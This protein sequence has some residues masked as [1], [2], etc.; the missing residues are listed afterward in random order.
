MLLSQLDNQEGTRKIVADLLYKKGYCL[1]IPDPKLIKLHL[2]QVSPSWIQQFLL[3]KNSLGL[4]VIP[5]FMLI[6][7]KNKCLTI[8]QSKRLLELLQ[9]L[10]SQA[11]LDSIDQIFFDNNCQQLAWV[12][13]I[14][15]ELLKF[16]LEDFVSSDNNRHRILTMAASIVCFFDKAS[17]FTII[18]FCLN[19]EDI[20]FHSLYKLMYVVTYGCLHPRQVIYLNT[21]SKKVFSTLMFEQIE[22]LLERLVGVLN[23]DRA[24]SMS[25]KRQLLRQFFDYL[26]EF[27]SLHTQEVIAL[28]DLKD[29]LEARFYPCNR[30]I[31]FFKQVSTHCLFF[32]CTHFWNSQNKKDEMMLDESSELLN[33]GCARLNPDYSTVNR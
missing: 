32:N 24:L 20:G 1:C 5:M 8:K 31:K 22:L 27:C 17:T 3:S 12:N 21:I 7:V 30:L 10:V 23:T 6:F 19:A 14:L 9:V 15:N 26:F 4:S 33:S 29:Q 28:N 2:E 13:Y 25:D 18:K 16:T 11:E